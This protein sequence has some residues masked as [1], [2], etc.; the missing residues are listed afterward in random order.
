MTEETDD[1]P[2]DKQS[3]APG[4]IAGKFTV[5]VFESPSSLSHV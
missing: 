1:L 4:V 3:G 2:G 5:S